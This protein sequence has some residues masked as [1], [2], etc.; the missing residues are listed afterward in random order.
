MF[1]EESIKYSNGNENIETIMLNLKQG[2]ERIDD[3]YLMA[4]FTGDELDKQLIQ[5]LKDSST[6]LGS[7][8][9][10]LFKNA[11]SDLELKR[12]IRELV[13]EIIP[14]DCKNESVSDE[15]YIERLLKNADGKQEKRAGRQECNGEKQSGRNGIN[16]K[17]DKEN[18]E[19]QH[20]RHLLDIMERTIEGELTEQDVI[21]LKQ[22]VNNWD[23]DIKKL[24][25]MIASLNIDSII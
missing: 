19:I 15:E 16:N 4:R 3:F 8:Y 18:P 9:A 12:C 11:E 21:E 17:N 5:R 25:K 14:K 1:N 20:I 7:W 10:T 24:K 22:D 2:I 23:E 6:K 13:E